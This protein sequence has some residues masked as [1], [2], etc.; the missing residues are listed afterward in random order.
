[1]QAED[2]A[3]KSGKGLHDKKNKPAHKVND[4]TGNATKCKN[5]F[6]SLQRAGKLT[7]SHAQI[8]LTLTL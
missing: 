8:F 1:M 4:M 7:V 6:P 2:K 3:I 5:F